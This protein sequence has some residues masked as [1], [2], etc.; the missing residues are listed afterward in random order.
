MA[1]LRQGRAKAGLR[2]QPASNLHPLGGRCWLGRGSVVFG[3]QPA[4]ARARRAGRGRLAGS[5]VW[6]TRTRRGVLVGRQ[7]GSQAESMAGRRTGLC[8]P[9]GS[10]ESARHLF[11]SPRRP[12]VRAQLAVRVLMAES[13]SRG[14][15][16]DGQCPGLVVDG[17]HPRD[18]LER[19]CVREGLDVKIWL[20]T[21]SAR[22][23]ASKAGSAETVA[24]KL[25]G[26][27]LGAGGGG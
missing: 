20:T 3:L 6:V 26:R 19:V 4:S 10:C 24:E 9:E 27:W 11:R 8:S 15:P 21:S 1:E 17:S 12:R 22:G 2:Q 18:T 14:G 23:P 13:E 7:T 25:A 5:Q 16:D